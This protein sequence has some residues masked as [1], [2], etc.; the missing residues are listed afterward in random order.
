MSKSGSF[1]HFGS[2]QD[3]QL[4]TTEDARQRYVRELIEPTLTSGAG[5]RRR[6]GANCRSDS[7]P[8]GTGKSDG[9]VGLPLVQPGQAGAG[10]ERPLEDRHTVGRSSSAATMPPARPAWRFV[11]QDLAL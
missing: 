2:K 5:M 8:V 9:V 3:L 7:R 1:L 11:H 4:A 10:L 6:S